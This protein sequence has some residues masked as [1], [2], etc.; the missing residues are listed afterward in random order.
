MSNQ[1][2]AETDADL[3][4]RLAVEALALP[5]KGVAPVV[6]ADGIL[7]LDLTPD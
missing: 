2:Y 4:A 6:S 5:P 1:T 3:S 7:T